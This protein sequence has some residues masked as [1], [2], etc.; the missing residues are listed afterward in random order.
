MAVQAQ[1]SWALRKPHELKQVRPRAIWMV[2]A[3]QVVTFA[4]CFAVTQTVAAI[5][6]PIFI[7]LMIP[8]RIFWY[9]KWLG[10]NGLA[11]LD[12][13]VASDFVMQSVGGHGQR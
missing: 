12:G 2:L 10:Q 8:V 4:A 1:R 6:F 13:P 11:L 5:A 9:P 3:L 7:V